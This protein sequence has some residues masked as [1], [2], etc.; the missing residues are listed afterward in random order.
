MKEIRL[1]M[2]RRKRTGR[3]SLPSRSA[4]FQDTPDARVELAALVASGNMKWGDRSHWIEERDRPFGAFMHMLSG[5][6]E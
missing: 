2:E 6:R 1:C 5:Q 4:W 3:S